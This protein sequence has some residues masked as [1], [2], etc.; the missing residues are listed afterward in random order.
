V[1]CAS[2]LWQKVGD[3]LPA[4]VFLPG[5]ASDERI[6]SGLD[7]PANR[8]LAKGPPSGELH[9]ELARYIRSRG[10]APVSLFGWSLGGFMAVEFSRLFPDLV[11]QLILCGVRR[12]YAPQEIALAKAGVSAQREM[13]LASFYRR[14]FLPAQKEDF[15]RFR[16]K[17]MPRYLR[18]FGTDELLRSLDYLAQARIRPEDL[19]GHP[20]CLLHGLHD[21]VAPVEEARAIAAA[22]VRVRLHVLPH[23][24]H[25]AFLTPPARPILASCLT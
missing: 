15:R 5:W 13:F 22:A 12:G 3:G 11:S 7:W 10:L 18:E 24:A 14:C 6:F 19:G 4:A 9:G 25:A 1:A 17:L 21:K 23:G 20:V 2:F 8:L 16:A